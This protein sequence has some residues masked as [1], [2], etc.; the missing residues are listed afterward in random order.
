MR[1]STKRRLAMT[2][3][4]RARALEAFYAAVEIINHAK[5]PAAKH[6]ETWYE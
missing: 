6:L 5:S 2:D 3:D 1:F 4:M